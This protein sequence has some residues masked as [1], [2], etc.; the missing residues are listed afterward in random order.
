MPESRVRARTPWF[1]K[2][3]LNPI[4]LRT[5]GMPV[6]SF[7]GRRTGKVWRTPIGIVEM[8]GARYLCSPRGETAWS[9]SL[10]AT[11]ECSIKMGGVERRY[12]ATEVSPAER[13][14]IFAEYVQKFAQTRS[15][16]EKLPDPLDHPTFRIDPL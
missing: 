4:L 9:R 15:A 16:F 14:P 5:G 7:S 3:V 2:N 11:G 6:V 10:R 8:N 13:S 12:R 1:I